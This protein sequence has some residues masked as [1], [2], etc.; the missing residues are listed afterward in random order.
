MGK[1]VFSHF[2]SGATVPGHLGGWWDRSA[3]ICGTREREVAVP[4]QPLRFLH[5]CDILVDHP[6]RDLQSLNRDAK[7]I[8]VAA[9]VTS[10]ERI[11]EAC[12]EH[13]VDF[14]LISGG[15]FDERDRSLRTRVAILDG[16]DSLQEAGIPVY[17][18]PGANDS[19]AAWKTFGELPENVTLFDA[20]SDA[21]LTV[22][23]NDRVIATI[24]A[25]DV[26]SLSYD[27]DEQAEHT[28]PKSVPTSNRRR[29]LHLGVV[30][31]LSSNAVGKRTIEHWLGEFSVDF[32]A[33]PSAFKRLSVTRGERLAH[34]PGAACS[35]SKHDLG[36]LGCTLVEVDEKGSL[37]HSLVATSPVRRE[38]F[39]I[40]V[41]HE[42]TWDGLV[43]EMR[44]WLVSMDHADSISLLL[45]DWV[46]VGDHRLRGQA[47]SPSDGCDLLEALAEP[48]GEQELFELLL[49][50]SPLRADQQMQHRLQVVRA[51]PDE[52]DVDETMVELRS[53]QRSSAMPGQP[54][55]RVLFGRGF[56]HRI[57]TEHSIVRSV[58][59]QTRK[60]LG[61]RESVWLKRLE[62]VAARVDEPAIAART[63][64]LGNEWFMRIDPAVGE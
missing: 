3:S 57:D 7:A 4:L 25:C 47:Q 59:E 54:N 39:E 20:L 2:R 28:Q 51:V 13:E 33:V 24:E 27:L 37:T 17:I 38:R 64:K 16:L 18:M 14:L 12:V 60:K 30:P 32:L 29:P 1:P 52:D 23:R 34:C 45:A 8:A 41:N 36:P 49:A 9:T 5:A 44:E 63:R 15:M 6:L 26:Q 19:L 48:S 11:I 22:L 46:L 10:L 40:N 55:A 35:F 62:N 43:S 56:M 58:L 61:D 50:D 31:A 53:E 42:T 21:P